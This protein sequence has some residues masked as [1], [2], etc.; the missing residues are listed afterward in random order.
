M[1]VDDDK[2]FLEEILEV[3]S[4][5][6]FDAVGVSDPLQAVEKARSLKPELILLDLRMPG[7]SGFQIADELKHSQEFMNLPVLAMSGFFTEV[8]HMLLMN[9]CGI[10]KCLKKPLNPDAVL[11]Q[12]SEVLAKTDQRKRREKS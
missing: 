7:R 6:G 10:Q 4:L 12:I 1:V 5:G 3:L 8:E 9:L 2:N 11:A